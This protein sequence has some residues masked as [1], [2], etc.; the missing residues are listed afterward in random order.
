MVEKSGFLFF[1]IESIVD[2]LAL[3]GEKT[4]AMF[5]GQKFVQYYLS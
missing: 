2:H 1:C 5:L 4:T 3:T